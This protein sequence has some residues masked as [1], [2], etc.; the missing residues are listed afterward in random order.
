M[1]RKFPAGLAVLCA[2]IALPAFAN[3][4]TASFTDRMK[5]K[6]TCI[7]AL[8]KAEGANALIRSAWDHKKVRKRKGKIHRVRHNTTCPKS[9]NAKRHI[10]GL[11][12]DQRKRYSRAKQ[13][14]AVVASVTP[15]DCGQYG[16]FAIPCSI[17]ACESGY[18]WDAYNP[19]GAIGPYQLL[20]K[21]AVWPVRSE[22]D[23]MEHHQIAYNLYAGGAGR[24]HW[25]CRG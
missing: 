25:V 21:G 23:K 1:T 16:H 17:V 6:P 14:A 9:L 3:G 19:S 13:R 12:K 8:H 2:F 4:P 11:V 20:G 10:K 24:S 5:A 22:A 15:Y 18:R 7:H